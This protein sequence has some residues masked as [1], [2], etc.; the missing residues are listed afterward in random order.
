MP[1]KEEKARSVI[2]VQMQLESTNTEACLPSIPSVL[3]G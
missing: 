2:R 3:E 1:Y